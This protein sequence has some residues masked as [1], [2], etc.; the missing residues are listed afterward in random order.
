MFWMFVGLTAW[1]NPHVDA[2]KEY[3]SK[4]MVEPAIS[5]FIQCI[6]KE[7]ITPI[8]IGKWAGLSG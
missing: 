1:A 2:G 7:P 4:K 5:E 6:E 8:A 3:L